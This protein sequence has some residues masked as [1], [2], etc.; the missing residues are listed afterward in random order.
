VVVTPGL[1]IKLIKGM[2]KRIKAVILV[3][4]KFTKY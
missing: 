1:L 4:G 2:P 3:D